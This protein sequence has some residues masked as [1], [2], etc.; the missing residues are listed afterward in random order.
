MGMI[1][2]IVGVIIGTFISY[3]GTVGINS[4]VNA[5]SEPQINW[6]LIGGTL[7]G[8][9]LIGSLAGIMPALKA[10]KLNPVD[11]LRG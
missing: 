8:S 2:G 10:A 4:W 1:G 3:V 9:F 11:A 5:T 7:F 6:I